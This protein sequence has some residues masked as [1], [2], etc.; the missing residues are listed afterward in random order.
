MRE[1]FA[2][3][4][5][6]KTMPILVMTMLLAGCNASVISVQEKD[7]NGDGVSDFWEF[8]N[9]N[10]IIRIEIDKNHDGQAERWIY[11]NNK[12]QLIKDRS[13][14]KHDD[15][16]NDTTFYYHKWHKHQIDNQEIWR[17]ELNIDKT[18][19][20]D[21]RKDIGKFFV[22]TKQCDQLF[23][24]MDVNND[25]KIDRTIYYKDYKVSSKPTPDEIK[26]VQDI[27]KFIRTQ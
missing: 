4:A 24:E 1:P 8:K 6:A 13:I 23:A 19:P 7:L 9:N 12:G 11:W 14:S 10:N 15:Y 17:N 25:G 16:E 20:K 27:Q 18:Y 22:Y 5:F 21:Q 26:K 2:R 3:S